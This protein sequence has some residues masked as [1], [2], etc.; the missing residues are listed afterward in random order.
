MNVNN[1]IKRKATT[2]VYMWEVFHHP[3]TWEY[4]ERNRDVSLEQLPTD[5]LEQVASGHDITIYIVPGFFAVVYAD[6]KEK[7]EKYKKTVGMPCIRWLIDRKY[8]EQE[9]WIADHYWESY[10]FHM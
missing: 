10:D 1:C 7:L 4:E 9:E 6:N 8:Q 3:C 2:K 5:E